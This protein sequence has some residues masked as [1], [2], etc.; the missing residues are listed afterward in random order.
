MPKSQSAIWDSRL[1]LLKG[2][3]L[4]FLAFLL[5][6]SVR[7]GEGFVNTEKLV[8]H[9]HATD[10][11]YAPESKKLTLFSAS[12]ILGWTIDTSHVFEYCN[13]TAR[14]KQVK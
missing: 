6:L 5:P 9:L 14:E 12:Q 2:K 3:Q 11:W 10:V 8:I 1:R 7:W 4:I 13:S